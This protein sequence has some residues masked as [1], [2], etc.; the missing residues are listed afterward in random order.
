MCRNEYL[1][2]VRH[3]MV[4]QVKL[5]IAIDWTIVMFVLTISYLKYI[6]VG[7]AG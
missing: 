2:C 1:V 7:K 5:K 6:F 4:D 3:T